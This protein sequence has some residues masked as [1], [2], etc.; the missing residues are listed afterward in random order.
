VREASV[1]F[2]P[3]QRQRAACAALWLKP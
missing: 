1:R 3:Q 2:G